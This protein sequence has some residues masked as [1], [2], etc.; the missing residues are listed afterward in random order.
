MFVERW[1]VSRRCGRGLILQPP[2]EVNL[3]FRPRGDEAVIDLSGAGWGATRITMT[4]PGKSLDYFR[5]DWEGL[6]SHFLP[7]PG[8]WHF[9]LLSEACSAAFDVVAKPRIVE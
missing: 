5:Y 8:V 6:A 1:R 7:A 4:G 3:Q 2:Y 9:T